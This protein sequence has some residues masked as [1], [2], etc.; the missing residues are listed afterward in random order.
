[1]SLINGGSMG[2]ADLR[3]SAHMAPYYKAI[4]MLPHHHHTNRDWVGVQSMESG[5]LGEIGKMVKVWTSIHPH[6]YSYF[7]LKDNLVRYSTL[8]SFNAFK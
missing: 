2:R 8:L 6:T 7:S 3:G 4:I 5:Y 1:M